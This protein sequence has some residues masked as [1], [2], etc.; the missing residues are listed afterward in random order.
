VCAP[1]IV[2]SR[3]GPSH[4]DSVSYVP[5]LRNE[6]IA[7]LVAAG[8][9]VMIAV[10][11][12]IWRK[13]RWPAL[14]LAAITLALAIPHLDL[15]FMASDTR[16]DAADDPDAPYPLLRPAWEDTLDET[17]ADRLNKPARLPAA[18]RAPR[19]GAAW[20]PETICRCCSGRCATRPTRLPGSMGVQ[21]HRRTE[22]A[23]A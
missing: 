4:G 3:F 23:T 13:L 16:L 1:Y 5:E 12:V 20:P 7:A 8:A 21:A 14:L 2:T 19:R 18:P 10:V 15:L 17:D 9:A 22:S 6:V 11:G